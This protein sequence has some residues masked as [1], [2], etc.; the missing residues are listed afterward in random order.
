MNLKNK[1]LP[2]LLASSLATMF[3]L[4]VLADQVK[5]EEGVP[6]RL[7]LLDTVSSG[8]NHEGDNVS[9]MVIDD[10][11]AADGTTVLIK[12]GT[13]AW[14]SVSAVKERGRMGEKGELSLAV[15][16]TKTIDG[17][18]V[19]LRASVNRN[20]EGKLGSVIALSLIVT[21]LF[22]L[23]RG[24]DAKV[25]AGSQVNAYIDREVLVEVPSTSNT[26]AVTSV[27]ATV[28]LPGGDAG[29]PAVPEYLQ[30]YTDNDKTEALKALE[31]LRGQG[32][33]TQAEYETK[34]SALLKK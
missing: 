19:P 18:K 3:P 32:V 28:K 4:S 25:P 30:K 16:G 26:N 21:P 31:S 6:V 10:I 20:G 11:M 14:G 13:P 9:F 17:K 33:L 34:K 29:T 24:K 2:L 12:S 27:S 8:T 7:K 5:L 22:L 15:S 1:V 23:M